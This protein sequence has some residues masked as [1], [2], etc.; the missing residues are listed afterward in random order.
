MKMKVL[1]PTLRKNN[2]YLTLDI[3]S[4]EPFSKDDIVLVVWDAC[5]RLFGEM[6]TSNFNLWVMRTYQL[7]D[8]DDCFHM[9]AILR[10]QRSFEDKVRSALCCI[11]KFN[12]KP[13]TIATI[14]LSGTISSSIDNFIKES[15]FLFYYFFNFFKK[16]ANIYI[17]N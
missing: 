12:G 14:G 5:I 15:T 3:K 16:D 9:K 2:R 11:T 13:I 8:R 1:P 17:L 4:K 7:D 10:C 6:E